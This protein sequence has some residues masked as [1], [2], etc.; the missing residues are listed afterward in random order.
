VIEVSETSADYDRS[1][2]RAYANAGVKEVLRVLGRE[3]Q[4]EVHRQPSE[5]ECAERTLR[6]PGARLTSAAFSGFTMDLSKLFEPV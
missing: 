2:L 5:G 3:K 4:I 6:G 1:K